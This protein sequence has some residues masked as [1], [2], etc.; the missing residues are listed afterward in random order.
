MVTEYEQP[1]AMFREGGS[2]R[3]IDA[4]KE[5]IYAGIERT[6]VRFLWIEDIEEEAMRA[7]MHGKILIAHY[8]DGSDNYVFQVRIIGNEEFNGESLTK[9]F[10]I[11]SPT[12]DDQRQ[13]FRFRQLFDIE[14]LRLDSHVNENGEKDWIK[15]QGIDLSDTGVGF[16]GKNSFHY[17]ERLQCRFTLNDV[18]Y[19]TNVKVVRIFD[20]AGD[21][22]HRLYRIGAQ[23]VNLNEHIQKRIRRY[24]YNQQ[25]SKR[26]FKKEK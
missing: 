10:L 4:G 19:V 6:G 25:V 23:F 11:T 9:L 20:Q 8:G 21:E 26:K 3:I 1:N 2:L 12:A 17:G 15:C 18:Q 13:A 5:P 16:A 7:D 22:K 14:V 24:I